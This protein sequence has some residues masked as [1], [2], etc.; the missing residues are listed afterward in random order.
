M[1]FEV[2]GEI[3]NIEIIA[4]GGQIRNIMRLRDQY[5]SGRWRKLKG[6]ATV[7]LANGQARKAE[8]HWHQADGIGKKNMKIKRFVE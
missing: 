7:P 4:G 3:R 8:V 6:I 2:A 1:H 5:G